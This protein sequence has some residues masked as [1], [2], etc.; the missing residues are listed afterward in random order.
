MKL[1][2]SERD[3][4]LLLFVL[5]LALVGGGWWGSKKIKTTNEQTKLQVAELEKRY[6]D[7]K[8]KDDDRAYYTEQT[9]KNADVYKGIMD[10][11]SGGLDQEHIIMSLKIGEEKSGAWIKSGTL[12][13]I[14][15]LYTFGDITSSDPN[16]VGQKVYVS[17]YIGVNSVL[18]L[19]FES[20][21]TELKDLVSYINDHEDK[22]KISNMTL[23]YNDSEDKLTGSMQL[24]T[25][26]IL[27]SDREYQDILLKDPHIG[28]DN[29]FE[30]STFIPS[31]TDGDYADFIKTNYDLFL[32]LH[33]ENK[34]SSSVAIGTMSDI[35]GTNTL[36]VSS[37]TT[38]K[39]TLIIMGKEGEYKF[40]YRLGNET[41]PADKYQLGM[42]YLVGDSLDLVIV[43]SPRVGDDDYSGVELSIAND[44]D[45]TLNYTVVN[46]DPE[47]PRF[48]IG[49]VT[50]KVQEY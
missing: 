36:S 34:D 12:A 38:E 42:D 49:T 44:S 24:V 8:S 13:G 6:T 31:T 14:S 17:D 9:T 40:A 33:H 47:R 37:N 5:I 3:L 2:I 39:V 41:V 45:L 22:S 23:T 30:S 27:G 26:G 18:N 29:I 20:T 43:S 28:T 16:R 21:Y 4:K 7:L 19:N 48:T 50:G 10:R 25:Y 46:D 15:S 11:Y 32:T 1:N 35:T